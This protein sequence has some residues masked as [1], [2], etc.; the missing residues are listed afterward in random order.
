[1][2]FVVF[3]FFC[4]F[5]FFFWGGGGGYLLLNLLSIRENGGILSPA[6]DYQSFLRRNFCIKIH[7]IFSLIHRHILGCNFRMAIFKCPPF[8]Q[9]CFSWI[10]LTDKINKVQNG[11]HLKGNQWIQEQF[12]TVFSLCMIS[13]L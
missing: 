9:N 6:Q 7:N 2:F 3:F 13:G 8:R 11:G 12:R 4:C 10:D 5:F 1:M